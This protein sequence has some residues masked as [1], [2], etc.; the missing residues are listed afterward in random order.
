MV[1]RDWLDGVVFPVMNLWRGLPFNPAIGYGQGFTVFIGILF[2]PLYVLGIITQKTVVHFSQISYVYLASLVSL[3]YITLIVTKYKKEVRNII[4]ISFI[5]FLLGYSGSLGLERGNTDIIFSLAMLLLYFLRIGKHGSSK[6]FGCIEAFTLGM[7]TASKITTL[8]IALAFVLTSEQLLPSV[9]YFLFSYGVWSFS[10]A[11]FGVKGT[12]LDSITASATFLHSFFPTT[13]AVSCLSGSYVLRGLASNFI[14]CSQPA[15]EALNVIFTI[16]I[17]VIF[18]LLIGMVFIS[19]IVPLILYL[20]KMNGS[21]M[22][23]VQYVYQNRNKFF[24]LLLVLAV[25]AIN[26][27]PVFSFSYRLYYSF[28]VLLA[29]WYSISAIK[30]KQLLLFSTLC[31]L[32]KGI[33]FVD[34]KLLNVLIALHYMSL[35][36]AVSLSLRTML[37]DRKDVYGAKKK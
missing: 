20:K 26:L 24:L 17:N 4:L 23:L 5:T 36:Y 30:A 2:Y 3:S 33:W 21:L 13:L 34:W 8:P 15:L 11:L 6:L 31:L 14:L 29:A 12:L 7:L 28:A 18:Y 10:P 1:G 16:I 35:I 22:L 9:L 27:L 25:A 32:L 19:P 37:P